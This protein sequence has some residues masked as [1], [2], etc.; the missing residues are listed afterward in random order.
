MV[1]DSLKLYQKK[2]TSI[3][4]IHFEKVIEW[5]ASG[6][7]ERHC[8]NCQNKGNRCLWKNRNRRKFYKNKWS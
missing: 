8:K 6:S 5:H 3:D 1:N 2:Q 7:R 4:S